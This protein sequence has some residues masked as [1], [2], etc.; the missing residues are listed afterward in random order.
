MSLDAYPRGVLV[1]AVTPFH[2]D[3]SVDAERFVDHCRWLLAEGA[4]GLAVFGTTSEANALSVAERTDLLERLIEGGIP[5]S[6]LL[7]GTGCCA[8]PDTVALTRHATQSGCFGVLMLPPFYYKGVSDDGLFASVAEVIERVAD[9]RLRIY[10]YHIPPMAGVG[11]VP[12]IERLLKSYRGV[13]AGIKDSRATGSA[14]RRCSKR[15]PASK[16][17]PAARPICS[18]RCG[19]AGRAA[20]RRPQT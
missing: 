14:R 19:L 10:L 8:L 20:S 17:F 5:A 11:L 3:L 13:V 1:P 4:S 18:T 16:S 12:L 7:P 9:D 15:S 6:V 2:P